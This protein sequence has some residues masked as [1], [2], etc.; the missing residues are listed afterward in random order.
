M[1]V[2]IFWD[3]TQCQLVKWDHMPVF[4]TLYTV[5]LSDFTV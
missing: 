2:P 5:K 4:S 1:K 3:V